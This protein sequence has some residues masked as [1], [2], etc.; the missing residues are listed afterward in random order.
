MEGHK[1]TITKNN[2]EKIKNGMGDKYSI[3]EE[4]VRTNRNAVNVQFYLPED[5]L[6]KVEMPKK[7]EISIEFKNKAK[8]S[9]IDFNKKIESDVKCTISIEKPRKEIQIIK[10]GERKTIELVTVEPMK[11]FNDE[12]KKIDDLFE[13]LNKTSNELNVVIIPEKKNLKDN[14]VVTF[15]ILEVDELKI[16][17]MLAHEGSND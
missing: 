2:F 16:I 5:S 12:K 10:K 14:E 8:N 4:F 17:K 11:K 6:P 1:L 13:S 9:D 3:V 15:P 7:K